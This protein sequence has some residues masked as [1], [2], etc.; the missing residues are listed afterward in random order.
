MLILEEP[1]LFILETKVI[2]FSCNILLIL[3][4]IDFTESITKNDHKKALLL[5]SSN[6]GEGSLKHLAI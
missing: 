6:A 5:I 3:V 4:L 1:K 2:Y